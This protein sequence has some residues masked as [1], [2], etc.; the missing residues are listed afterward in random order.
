MDCFIKK[1]FQGSVDEKIHSQ[2][3]RFGKGNYEGRAIIVIHKTK[4][5]KLKAS[6]EY[7]NDFVNL[8]SEFGGGIVSGIVLSKDDIS[9]TIS[10]NNIKANSETKKGGLFYKNN[11]AEQELNKEQIKK[12]LDNSYFSLL[13]IQGKDFILKIKK[14][15]PKPGKSGEKKTDDKFCQLEANLKYFSQIKEAFFWDVQDCKKIKAMHTYEINE[16]IIPQGEKD[17]EKI[18]LLTKRKGKIIRKLEIDK[19]E[20]TKEKELEV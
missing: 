14:K 12:L 8:V 3:V 20:E 5:I 17:F 10:E 18:R 19:R 6:F 13:D 4:K 2:F 7:A 16:L 9:N 1:I 11:L 15:I